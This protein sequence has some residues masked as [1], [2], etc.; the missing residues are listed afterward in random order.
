M[1]SASQQFKAFRNQNPNHLYAD[2]PPPPV[3]ASMR[4]WFVGLALMNPALMTE[5][6]LHLR[7]IEAVKLADEL[8]AALAAPRTPS[9]ES[10]KPPTENELEKWSEHVTKVNE[11]NAFSRRDTRPAAPISA[12]QRANNPL[13]ETQQSTKFPEPAASSRRPTDRFGDV[14]PLPVGASAMPPPAPPPPPDSLPSLP[15][16]ILPPVMSA[17]PSSGGYSPFEPL[18][19]V[20]NVPRDRRVLP[21]PTSYSN[22]RRDR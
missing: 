4:E 8:L 14:L 7:A 13:K 21:A 2:P 5:V 18:P 15:P 3:G 22:V 10:L 20:I 6:P 17:G 19:P 16:T 11:K 1:S 12:R 9:L